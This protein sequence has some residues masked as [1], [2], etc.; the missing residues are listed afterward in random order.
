MIDFSAK[1]NVWI[2]NDDGS[3]NRMDEPYYKCWKLADGVWRIL[4]SGDYSYLIEG[5]EEGLVIDSGYGAGNLRE[6]IQALTDKPVRCIANTHDHFDHTAN[7][8]YFEAAYMAEETVPLATVPFP[9][10]AGIDFPKDYKIIP[11]KNGDIIPLKGR[12]L[13]AILVPDHAVGSMCYLDRKGRILFSG[14]EFFS[15]RKNLNYGLRHWKESLE[16]LLAVR[17]A[18]DIMYGGSGTVDPSIIEK[19]YQAALIGLRTGG[20]RLPEGSG[21]GR[22]QPEYNEKGE[23]V[24]DRMKPHYEDTDHPATSD[25]ADRRIVRFEDIELVFDIT[26]IND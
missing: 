5:G 25:P 11:L 10:F 9:S 17:D 18:F 1:H 19:Q 26:K 4:S 20:T 14:D 13:Q 6:Y 2:R 7:N 8:S 3:L 15:L 16:R 24:Y 23:P 22:P 21:G 12:E